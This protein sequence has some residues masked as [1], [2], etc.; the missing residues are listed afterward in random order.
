ML[1]LIIVEV[2]FTRVRRHDDKRAFISPEMHEVNSSYVRL[3]IVRHRAIGST[4]CRKV[5]KHE[6]WIRDTT[7]MNRTCIIGTSTSLIGVNVD[8]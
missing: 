5:I 4:R 1:S 3:I 7:T 8:G 6:G 2:S